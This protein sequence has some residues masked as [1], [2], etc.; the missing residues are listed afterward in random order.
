MAL[1]QAAL[2][3]PRPTIVA[4]SMLWSTLL[5]GQA[6][7]PAVFADYAPAQAVAAALQKAAALAPAARR[8]APAAAADPAALLASMQAL[9]TEVVAG[10]LGSDVPADQPLMEAGLDSLGEWALASTAGRREQHCWQ[11]RSGCR[12][13][14]SF[15]VFALCTSET[16]PALP[17]AAGAVELRNSLQTKLDAELPATLT[18]DYPSISALAGYL[19]ANHAPASA[20]SGAAA[21]EQA[22]PVAASSRGLGLPAIL[23]ALQGIVA[24]MLGSDV[25]PDQPLM[26]AGVDSLGAWGQ[27]AL[28][29][30]CGRIAHALFPRH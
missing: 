6:R 27:A 7:V 11:C 8:A 29:L 1:L 26:E 25:P 9:V 4:A 30:S 24:G 19:A 2:G 22:G 5:R 15:L 13:A 12:P 18:F 21:A 14:S 28:G 17:S 10:M 16:N 20:G 23:E 3:S